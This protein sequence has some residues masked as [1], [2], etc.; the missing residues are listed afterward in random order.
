M[1][2]DQDAR[3]GVGPKKA[4]QISSPGSALGGLLLV[5]IGSTKQ[6]TPFNL[7]YNLVSRTSSPSVS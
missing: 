5:L 2:T 6:M 1:E 3:V 7:H 4:S